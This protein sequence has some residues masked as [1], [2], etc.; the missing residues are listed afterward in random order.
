MNIENLE[1]CENNELV[2]SNKPLIYMKG[3]DKWF[4]HVHA[5][6]NVDL[7][8]YENEIV[9]LVGD[10][11]AGKSTLIKILSGLIKADQGETYFKD[12]LVNIQNSRDAR[13]LGIGTV[14]QDLAL[15]DCLDVSANLFL[16][17]ELVRGGIFTNR[18]KMEGEAKKILE[19]LQVKIKSPKITAGY[20]SGGQRQ[21]IAIGRV[22][23]EDSKVFVLDEPTAALGVRE[24]GEVLNL[25]KD[26]KASGRTIII[27]SHQLEEVFSLVDR[28]LVLRQGKKVG[29]RLVSKT[30][31]E[32]IIGMITGIIRV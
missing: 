30:T 27:I 24:T 17:K 13:N 7:S 5:L 9:A 25:I 32:E 19:R 21:A 23:L 4:G 12:K 29:E 8:I 10:N 11:G 26:L 2:N 3:I 14:Y 18:E 22:I 31:K 1:S 16:G 20:L 28:I 15:V 6:D